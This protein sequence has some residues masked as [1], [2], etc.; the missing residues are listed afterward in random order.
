M[1]HR[2]DI[3]Q[4]AEQALRAALRA[5]LTEQA[6][7]ARREIRRAVLTAARRDRRWR[8]Y[9]TLSARAATV[10]AVISLFA[11]AASAAAGTA[12][13]GEPGYRLKRAAERLTL[14]VLPAGAVEDPLAA[15]FERRRP[16][17]LRRVSGKALDEAALEEALWEMGLEPP[18]GFGV[19]SDRAFDI[20][21]RELDRLQGS[22]VRTPPG[23]GTGSGSDSGAE[24]PEGDQSRPATRQPHDR[25]DP[26]DS[27]PGSSREPSA[28]A[29]PG[30]GGQGDSAP[31]P[32]G[33]I[34]A[35]SSA[36]EQPRQNGSTQGAGSRQ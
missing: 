28:P 15:R 5:A 11:A 21:R 33:S 35:T 10:L 30:H 23:S 8:P 13:P 27:A 14:S 31:R 20:I 19:K 25:T 34:D 4:R 16:V 9:R 18:G 6:P 36:H 26:A 17:E 29:S 24:Q 12:L 32:G 1:P 2:D 7:S 3:G 22:P